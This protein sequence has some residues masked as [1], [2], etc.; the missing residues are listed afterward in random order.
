MPRSSSRWLVRKAGIQKSVLLRTP[1]LLQGL[2]PGEVAARALALGVEGVVDDDLPALA[3]GDQHGVGQVVGVADVAE[4][5]VD[6]DPPPAPDQRLGLVAVEGALLA[7]AELL[8]DH[9]AQ[10]AAA[11]AVVV[12]ATGPLEDALVVDLGE[13]DRDDGVV[14]LADLHLADLGGDVLHL[15]QD[16]RDLLA[17]DPG[18]D[19][20][21]VERREPAGGEP[22]QR[23]HVGGQRG[24]QQRLDQPVV[25]D[26][27]V[28]AR[29]RLRL[30]VGQLVL[31]E[32]RPAQLDV[33]E[34]A[35]GVE[36]LLELVGDGLGV[37][38]DQHVEEVADRHQ[39][40]DLAARRARRRAAGASP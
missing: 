9:L 3:L 37:A 22:G 13:L 15:L 19:G 14:A 7:D 26:E 18:L 16:D 36:L 8:P 30:L 20:A 12:D 29:Q 32:Q 39:V 34:P 27:G 21:V 33:V 38:V 11:V 6:R 17:G 1:A 35:R 5:Q 23:R 25:G 24:E 10:G 31:V 40:V 28:R 4:D 2:H